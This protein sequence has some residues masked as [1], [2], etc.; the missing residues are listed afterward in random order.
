MN[1]TQNSELN[2]RIRHDRPLGS[3]PEG[4]TAY[5]EADLR[6]HKKILTD[7]GLR[8]TLDFSRPVALM[9][10]AI[11]HFLN[12]TD[13]P[14]RVVAQLAHALPE[15]SYLVASHGTADF[16]AVPVSD[17]VMATLPQ[18]SVRPRTKDEFATF[19]RR[20]GPR[21]SGRGAREHLARRRRGPAATRF[22]RRA[23][24]RRRCQDQLAGQTRLPPA[25]S[26]TDQ[27]TPPIDRYLTSR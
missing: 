21:R 27:T 17:R 24:V 18:G 26:R 22:L 2:M 14:Y 19:L 8:A 15:G 25:H 6:D 3:A 1:G 12:D 4:R 7:Q 5:L 23:G 13:D 9:L 11:L 16:T 20:H 10:I